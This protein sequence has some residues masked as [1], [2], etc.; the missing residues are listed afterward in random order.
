[1][2]GHRVTFKQATAAAY[3]SSDEDSSDD[4]ILPNE[5]FNDYRPRKRRRTARDTKESAALGVFGSDSEDDGPGKR[6]K[7]KSLR[8]KGMSFVGAEDDGQIA[9][10]YSDENGEGMDVDAKELSSADEQ[11]AEDDEEETGFRGF[12]MGA[13]SGVPTFRKSAVSGDEKEEPT[14]PR[15]PF[16]KPVFDGTT[17]FGRGFVSASANE[18]V[19]R[20]DLE[21]TP[22]PRKAM[23][24]AFGPKS[25]MNK[26][27]FGAKMMAKMGYQEGKGLGKE[28]QG[29][30]VIVEANLR[31]QGAGLGA[32]K[33]KTDQERKEEKRQAKMRGE[34]VSDSEEEARKKRARKQ[35]VKTK[36]A[37]GFDSTAS[38]PKRQKPRYMTADEIKRTAPGLHIPDAFMPILDMTGPGSKVVSASGISTPTSTAPESEETVATRKVLRQA[39]RDLAAFS[40]EWRN[41]ADRGTWVEAQLAELEQD[42]ETMT[43]DYQR[44]LDFSSIVTNELPAA[45]SDWQSVIVCLHKAAN[46]SPGPQSA[47]TASIIV[48]ALEPFFKDPEWD[49]LKEP[50]RYATD[51]KGLEGLLMPDTATHDSVEKF[52]SSMFNGDSIYRHHHRSTTPYESLMYRLWLPRALRASRDSDVSDPAQLMAILEHWDPL[53]PS[54][55]HAEFLENVTRRLHTTLT[56]WNP[57]RRKDKDMLPHIWLFPWLPFLP[58]HHLDPKGSG[59]VADVRRKFRQLIEAWDFSRGLIPGLAKWKG[60]LGKEWKGLMVHV[61]PS[62]GRYLALNFRVDPADQEPYLAALEGILDWTEV[63]GRKYVAEVVRAKVFPMWHAKL[64]EWFALGA[65]ADLGEI[66]G[67]FEWWDG[68]FPAEVGVLVRGEFERGLLTIERALDRVA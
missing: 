9:G 29:R 43:L 21:E 62:M 17:P 51:M 49:L 20:S 34:A 2:E 5:E 38:T 42:M 53:L 24:S 3:S 35:K 66:A 19:L 54:F 26:N 16:A 60:V 40:E 18:P 33:E 31:P 63:L 8:G 25:K 10:E 50:S 65:E 4:N 46:V 30:N 52:D 55:I 45:G 13:S 47:E 37:G 56:E 67:W 1:M 48:A 36:G 7:A 61:L 27:S 14:P 68:Y 23:P 6:W 22:P 39:H 28:A 44:L 12:R 32:V 15:Q 64:A 58:P 57:R 11:E 59:L 41:L